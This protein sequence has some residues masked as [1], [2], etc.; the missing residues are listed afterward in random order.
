MLT[1]LS[2]LERLLRLS[3]MLESCS[4]LQDGGQKMIGRFGVID[5]SAHAAPSPKQGLGLFSSAALQPATIA[6]LYPVHAIGDARHRLTLS[7]TDEAYFKGTPTRPYSLEPWHPSLKTWA[8]DLWIDANPE[9]EANAG[10]LGHLTNDAATCTGDSDDEVVQY[11]EA[12]TNCVMLPF[13]R[14]APL[15]CVFTTRDVAEGEEL[16]LSCAC[17]TASPVAKAL[18][19]VARVSSLVHMPTQL[20]WSVPA[21]GQMGTTTGCR[22]ATVRRHRHTPQPCCC[23]VLA[24]RRSC[25]V[26]LAGSKS[27]MSQKWRSWRPF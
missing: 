2:N 10:W 3:S 7:D 12:A 4:A 9:R 23:S 18:P 15:M 24:G 26:H 6:T 11:Y 22:V 19:L 16:L 20:I 5:Q 13:G 21:C 17:A 8:P 27:G 14:A 25:S 1:L